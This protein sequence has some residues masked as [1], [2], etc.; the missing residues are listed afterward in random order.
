MPEAVR[1]SYEELKRRLREAEDALC[2]AR[3]A[4]QRI[5]RLE[6]L[7]SW[8]KAAAFDFNNLMC[9]VLGLSELVVHHLSPADPIHGMMEEIGDQTTRPKT[10][11]R[12]AECVRKSSCMLII[13]TKCAALGLDCSFCGFERCENAAAASVTCAYN[14]GDLGI[15][16]GSA[17]DIASRF[18][19][20]N[21]ILYTAG[22]T[23]VKTGVFEEDV[24]MALGIPLSA[25][26]KNPF[27]DR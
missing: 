9:V 3:D 16:V 24:R 1:P 20:D 22:Y 25:T 7:A 4:H 6:A 23:A 5:E 18:H 17:A 19:V 26:G 12:D 8:A 27:F 14:S 13:G 15:A 2:R 21:R 11:T 10:F